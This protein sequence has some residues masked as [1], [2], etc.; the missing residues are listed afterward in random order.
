M[1]NARFG[2]VSA[3]H[4][5]RIIAET[6]QELSELNQLNLNEPASK[7]KATFD[8]SFQSDIPRIPDNL[9][10]IETKSSFSTE[11]KDKL[12][13]LNRL[14][15]EIVSV[16]SSLDQLCVSYKKNQERFAVDTA[17]FKKLENETRSIFLRERLNALSSLRDEITRN[18]KVMIDNFNQKFASLSLKLDKTTSSE[19]YIIR[20]L[21]ISTDRQLN[22]DSIKADIRLLNEQKSKIDHDLRRLKSLNEIFLNQLADLQSL[23]EAAIKEAHDNQQ[24]IATA[25]EKPQA[26]P[27]ITIPAEPTTTSTPSSIASTSERAQ[28]IKTESPRQESST[29]TEAHSQTSSPVSLSPINA[30]TSVFF[31]PS[32]STNSFTS[33][34]STPRAAA[35]PLEVKSPE[36]QFSVEEFLNSISS[37]SKEK[38]LEEILQKFDELR[39]QISAFI[40]GLLASLNK[41][42][43]TIQNALQHEEKR[44]TSSGGSMSHLNIEK[45]D[46]L[47]SNFK[48]SHLAAQQYYDKWVSKAKS[49]RDEALELASNEDQKP[50]INQKYSSFESTLD[51]ISRATLGRTIA[52]VFYRQKEIKELD[53]FKKLVLFIKNTLEESDHRHE[54]HFWR[55]LEP[56]FNSYQLPKGTKVQK[57]IFEIYTQATALESVFHQESGKL[58][59]EQIKSG[60]AKIQSNVREHLNKHQSERTSAV[61][62]ISSSRSGLLF[63]KSP[64]QRIELFYAGLES[65]LSN[66]A[67]LSAQKSDQTNLSF[68]LTLG[69]RWII[70]TEAKKSAPQITNRPQ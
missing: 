12:A 6:E 35:E 62:K 55:A 59:L 45:L 50:I 28:E 49:L 33:N 21:P 38:Q 2:K 64:S 60:L 69:N 67:Q 52:E 1:T 53:Q 9:N 51:Q 29:E 16:E 41:E 44:L 14:A 40:K 19:E 20:A 48:A 37:K 36:V 5:N 17:N 54:Y 42:R 61:K 56:S 15:A 8:E 57:R 25:E 58:N 10:E 70:E 31:Q 18:N 43:E 63:E 7:A 39:K 65:L 26:I 32:G 68:L 27:E 22:E 47:F 46:E 30:S 4:L 13:Y 24:R 11:L 3:A 66:P 34:S 23:Q